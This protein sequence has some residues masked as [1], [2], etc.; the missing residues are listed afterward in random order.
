M[1]KLDYFTPKEQ[2]VLDYMADCYSYAEISMY[3]GISKKTLLKHIERIGLKIGIRT[4]IPICR[5]ARE[6]G[7]GKRQWI[8]M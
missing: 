5:Y 3:M 1:N 4:Q 2:E 8:A 7:Y 6:Q